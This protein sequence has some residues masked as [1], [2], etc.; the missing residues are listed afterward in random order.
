MKADKIRNC[1]ITD[2][3][4]TPLKRLLILVKPPTVG[5]FLVF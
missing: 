3:Q 5:L 4:R 1:F 2:R